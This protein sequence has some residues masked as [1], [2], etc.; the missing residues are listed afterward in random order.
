MG[1]RVGDDGIKHF[2]HPILIVFS[3]PYSLAPNPPILTPFS[4]PYSPVSLNVFPTVGT[5]M[6]PVV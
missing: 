1:T 5:F 2:N 3:S 6:V 4:H